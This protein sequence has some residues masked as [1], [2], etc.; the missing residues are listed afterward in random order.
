MA[1][2]KEIVV[3]PYLELERKLEPVRDR[4]A[5]VEGFIGPTEED[6][7]WVPFVDKVWI[8][9]LAFDVRNNCAANVLWVEAGGGLGRHRHRGQVTGFCLE[10]SFRYLEY[11]WVA[12]PGSFLRES[13]GRTHTLYSD[14][15]TKTYFWLQ[16]ALEFLDE[17]DNITAI[18]DVFWYINHYLTYCKEHNLPVNEKL[19]L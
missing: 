12:T 4:F 19:F 15:G 14:N 11:D 16:G 1:V 17:N 2:E 10:G 9:H 7:P 3:P 8:R 6:S 13:P 18:Y 5:I